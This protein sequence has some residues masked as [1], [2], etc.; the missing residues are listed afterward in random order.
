M[1][2]RPQKSQIVIVVVLVIVFGFF[3]GFKNEV[4]RWLRVL[5]GAVAFGF[6]GWALCSCAARALGGRRDPTDPRP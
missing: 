1:M 3:G 4:N 2:A 6:L 5:L